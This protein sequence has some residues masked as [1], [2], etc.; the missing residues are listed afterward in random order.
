M[1]FFSYKYTMQAIYLWHFH[2]WILIMNILSYTKTPFFV[3]V[4]TFFR[5]YFENLF[6]MSLYALSQLSRCF[7]LEIGKCYPI[8][9]HDM[10]DYV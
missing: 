1:G 10:M 7:Y 2:N 8:K 3:F 4:G 9:Y 6:L 5:G